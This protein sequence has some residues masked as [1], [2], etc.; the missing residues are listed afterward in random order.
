MNTVK[1]NRLIRAGDGL[2]SGRRPAEE[3]RVHSTNAFTEFVKSELDQSIP[4]RF[5]KQ[6]AAHGDR[7]AVK[8]S[9]HQLTY[10]ALNRLANQI[11]RA[12]L[13]IR[14]G[15]QEA[16]AL[17]LDHDAPL[18]AA[19]LG[20][21]KAGHF[22]VPLEASYPMER[23]RYILEDSQARLILTDTRNESL[24]SRLGG[25]GVAVLNIEDL[26]T[27]TASEDLSNFSSPDSVAYI[28][29]TSGSTGQPKGVYQLHRNVLHNMLKYTNSVHLCPGDRLSLLAS[30]GFSASVT[31]I[32][33][34]L[35]NGASIFPFNLKER[36]LDDL[37]A[38]LGREEITVYHSIP[39]VFR[40]LGQI[41]TKENG[42]PKLRLIKLGGEAVYRKD[43]E[44]YRRCFTDQC[45]LY[46]G[47]GATEMGIIRLFLLDKRT[48]FPGDTVP[49]G[50]GTADTEVLLLDENGQEARSGEVGEIAIRSEYLFPGYWRKSDLTREV[51]FADPE[52]GNQRIYRSGDLGRF[53]PGG[54]LLHMGR[55]DSQVKIRGH[56]VE[57]AEVEMALMRIAGVREAV[58]IAR[59]GQHG[60]KTLV[61][62][63]TVDG[64]PAPSTAELRGQL[65]Q[66]LPDSMIPSAF[67]R[68]DS[69]PLTSTGKVDRRAL[70]APDQTRAELEE[71]YV[72]PRTPVE[73]VLADIWAEV[74]GMEQVGIH[75]NFFELGG[76]SILA[77][78]I[79]GRA[80]RR[81]LRLTPRQLFESQT[82]AELATVAVSAESFEAEQG[83]VTGLV[84]LTPIQRRFFEQDLLDPHH[85]TQSVLLEAREALD[86][87]ALQ[88][89]VERLMAHHDALRL[90]FVRG[91]EG[92]CQ[93]NAG[94]ES[95]RV[96][97]V[98][99][100]RGLDEAR[101]AS[102]IEKAAAEAQSGLNLSEG[103]I[104]RVLLFDLGRERPARLL[105]V[106]HHLAVDGISWRVLLEDLET[107]YRLIRANQAAVLPPKTTSF[108]DWSQKL[109]DFARSRVPEREAAYWLSQPES[110]TAALPLD[111]EGENT[112][113][114][115]QTVE[116]SLSEGETKALLQEVPP[117][118]GTQINDVLLK[119]LA[120]AFAGWTGSRSLLIDLEG[121]GREEVVPGADL[122]RTVGW[123]TTRFPVPLKLPESGGPGEALKTVKEQ[124]RAIP[125]RG[126]GYGL[127]R[128]L[129][130]NEMLVAKLK[131]LPQPT[132]SF[133]YLGQ[134]DQLL[135]E[136]S[137]FSLG[138][139]VGPTRSPRDRRRHVLTLDG[140]VLGGRLRFS[141]IFSQNL[142]RRETVERVATSFE[143]ALRALIAHCRSPEAG[144]YTPSEFPQAKLGQKDI[145]TSSEL[146]S[147]KRALLE[148]M[149]REEGLEFSPG[150]VIPRRKEAEVAPLSFAQQRLW[151]LDC[152][153]PGSP[154]YNIPRAI[155]MRG[156]LDVAALER[157]LG[158]IVGR[159]ESLRT[160]IATVDGHPVQRIAPVG[161]WSLRLPD[162]NGF[163][164]S[165]R[166]A[167]VRR[168]AEEEVRRPFDLG[169]GPLFRANLLRIAPTDHLL[170]VTMHNIVSD[171][172]S[173]G[174]FRREFRDLYAAYSAGRES[175]LGELPVQYGDFAAWQRA[176][177][178]GN[179]LE[180]QLSYW[181]EQL[182]GLPVLELPTDR[183]RPP[184]Q[185][186]RGARH[187]WT[188]SSGLTEA[189]KRLGHQQGCT[190]F[191]TLLAAFN[192][193]L[194]RYS[195]QDDIVVGS[196]IAGR[197]HPDT[198]GLI[199]FFLNTLVLRTK[200]SGNPTFREL[201]DRV[202]EVALGAYAHQDLP[203]EKLVEELQPERTRSHNPLFQV[204][205]V[206]QNAPTPPAELR[207]LTLSPFEIDRGTARFD[208]TVNLGETP[209]GLS[210]FVEY[211]T[212]L[213]ESVTVRRMLGHFR[214]LLEGIVADPDQR[215]SQLRLLT[216][217]ERRQWP[218]PSSRVRPAKS[219][220][221]FPREQIEQSIPERF[222]QQVSRHSSRIAVK[223]RGEEWT[224]ERL[225][226][227]ADRVARAILK[228][229]GRAPERVALLLEQ[230]A[231]MVAAIL[232][233]LKAR[234]T[235]V[236]LD[237]S[238]PV[239]RLSFML[240][241]SEVAA[242]LTND[243]NLSLANLLAGGR[244][245]VVNL[246]RAGLPEAPVSQERIEPDD[247]AYI[248]YTSGSTGRPK[249][250]VQN[251]RNVLH[252][253]RVYTNQLHIAAD[254]RLTLLATYSFD[255]AVMDIFG[256]LLNGAALCPWNIKE[257]GLSGLADWLL[258]EG[259]T[260]FHAVPTV[261]RAFVGAL[262]GRVAFPK[263][264]LVVLGGEEVYRADA[265]LYKRHFSDS[266]LFVNGLG[267][268]ES[269]VSLQFFLD[270]HTEISR[271]SVPVG[272]PVEDT[273]IV[274]LDGEGSPTELCGE[275][276]IRSPYLALGYWR[277]PDQTS[278]SFLPDPE[279]GERR[280]FRT[281]D[282]GR[283]LPDGSIQFLGRKDS[284]IKIRGYRIEPGEIES[285]LAQ[286][287]SV[288]ESV[289]VAREDVPGD[290]RLVA[291]VVGK[292]G[293]PGSRDLR[294][295]LKEKL[296]DYMVPSAFVTLEAL[297]WT[298]N[299][300]VDRK[301]LPAPEGR[302]ELEKAYVAPRTPTEEV[303]AGIWAQVLGLD[304]VGVHY[305]FFELGGHSLL[306]MLVFAR[307]QKAFPVPLPLR[308]L[309][310][311][312]TVAELSAA[313]EELAG[314][315]AAPRPSP[316]IPV[317]RQALE[318]KA[319][320][321]G[322]GRDT[323]RKRSKSR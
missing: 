83:L 4:D 304:R 286:Q 38:W 314:S 90:R 185:S 125:E 220:A 49:I 258:A 152:L 82:V 94:A 226:R 13:T 271:S 65:M 28:L 235:Y 144:G 173:M 58:V 151:F 171:G 183:P 301:A 211:C 141:W 245:S 259:I 39:S 323:P 312:P 184:A 193:L 142:H 204:L 140:R 280:I 43:V 192:T 18:V 32:L 86:P 229:R 161:R 135:S 217:E 300:K 274:L 95:P 52:G 148:A 221:E 241:D 198:E 209:E 35:L 59:E 153:E 89:A 212:D 74:L 299:G 33:G 166:E 297:P 248:L 134:F 176:W 118:Y 236:P 168:V 246:D 76:D 306:A 225:S 243:R 64:A 214:T 44:L 315:A 110:A 124:L 79:I 129:G 132:V 162:L 189:L 290:K 123:F 69:L 307:L 87:E 55:K 51:L 68:L 318:R 253:M 302:P 308:A 181:R 251:H 96:F 265:D 113:E 223:T 70:P 294:G 313:I 227:E 147:K 130:P 182:A 136:G 80:A 25:D 194:H 177:L 72:A 36:S 100:L 78:Q 260:I 158:E 160:T 199:G 108:R 298:P 10:E 175:T 19:I 127:L 283:L 240:R 98:L 257:E 239:D 269:T 311:K 310:E 107:A 48:E 14:P 218:G 205:L 277:L 1:T 139:S 54:C 267:P 138:Q 154:A 149:L 317:S 101:Q 57:I 21:L 264:R 285:A 91:P 67:V 179:V 268:T 60:D 116:T 180:R 322:A 73:E 303:L 252:F 263:V 244:C 17:L 279:G 222:D 20:T 256:A 88:G 131:S 47:L 213:F 287:P 202:R 190:L 137:V 2:S 27:S 207:G 305:N 11:A 276:G 111:F 195:G 26:S 155:R 106:V 169:R 237:V 159:H 6:V 188:L 24:A 12:V 289:V 117:V 321:L 109:L 56:R 233:S 216:E 174:V 275:I 208:L 133:N 81:S 178:S 102:A 34:A 63:L 119:A 293:M 284:L 97:S 29:Y 16:V 41:L 93:S 99:S 150:R 295:F 84:P 104:A 165:E 42:L 215:L 30:A 238:Y 114:S 157:S 115:A 292:Q 219:F 201:L 145:G 126:I 50:Y 270:R 281:G 172:W 53:L 62:Y 112:F 66:R 92:W 309:F 156:A 186:F 249:G 77:I 37:A 128:Y 46:V 105:F 85:Y 71:N 164:E 255:A 8:T 316:I 273:E 196:P 319:A 203:F 266:C 191:M 163:S 3:G 121:H 320:A 262:D 122:S 40:H 103:P 261:Y 247:V 200:L 197:N 143:E 254:D 7:L 282:V 167:E 228:T 187:R 231:P 242:I 31:D 5:Q 61:A 45:I 230:D 23:Q 232:G 250:V 291:Y 272:R 22:Y 9:S 296:P 288:A 75:D 278:Q 234:K 120:E 170:L 224:Y 210:G 15:G 146:S 206:L